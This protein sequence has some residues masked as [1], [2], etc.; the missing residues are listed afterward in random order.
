V[1]SQATCI[2]RLELRPHLFTE[3]FVVGLQVCYSCAVV[4]VGKL[5]VVQ[6]VLEGYDPSLKLEVLTT[7]PLDSSL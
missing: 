6:S 5:S 3:V 1:S 7:N 4:L 2:V